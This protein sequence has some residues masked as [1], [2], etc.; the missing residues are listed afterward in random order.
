MDYYFT[1]NVVDTVAT[2]RQLDIKTGSPQVGLN[3]GR[4]AV[5]SLSLQDDRR[6]IVQQPATPRRLTASQIRYFQ[7]R[8]EEKLLVN[9]ERLVTPRIDYSVGKPSLVVREL[10][11]PER[12]HYQANYDWVT[13][14]LAFSLFLFASIRIPYAKYLG[15]MFHSLINYPSST[16]L[17]R[18]QNY[19]VSHG[20]F[21]LD[22]YFYFILSLFL[23]LTMK[24]FSADLPL[25]D[26]VMFLISF[27]A[28]LLYFMLKRML[29]FFTGSAGKGRPLASEYWFNV[30][31]YNR[32]LGLFLFPVVAL[33]V[34]S[35]SFNQYY[36][37]VTG[38]VF[39][40][41]FYGMTLQRG[42]LILLKK[43]FSIFYLFLYL[44]TLE[45]L[46]LVLIIKM[47]T[48]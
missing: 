28:V 40:I 31:N 45:I 4:S 20:A 7:A 32:A 16:R 26:V 8:E 46:P 27:A 48:A 39:I 25:P 5:S 11:L 23:F 1:Y 41:I 18:E 24:Y 30:D 17:F 21:R 10:I 43:Q 6:E 38:L 42:I 33:L 19:S 22:V 14:I 3:A 29:Y 44:C 9:G 2:N 37:I 15:H 35:P 47:V 13:I 12:H 36:L 34:F